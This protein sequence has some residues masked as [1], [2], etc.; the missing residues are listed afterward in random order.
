[1][2]SKP[3]RGQG[4][5]RRTWAR[6]PWRG[7]RGRRG[8]RRGPQTLGRAQQRR[9]RAPVALRRRPR[10]R[11]RRRPAA[12][13]SCCSR[14][15]PRQGLAAKRP[16]RGTRSRGGWRAWTRLRRRRR[17]PPR[18]SACSCSRCGAAIMSTPAGRHSQVE[19]KAR[20]SAAGRAGPPPS[21]RP[22]SPTTCSA[23]QPFATAASATPH[24]LTP[25]LSHHQGKSRCPARC[26]KP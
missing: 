20:R 26:S 3:R 18:R 16:R 10:Q 14:P 2:L 12:R 1:M 22:L 4:V 8:W 21:S 23:P 11:W 19:G 5:R 13:R 6:R 7:R 24:R 25:L 9:R 15:S 17:P